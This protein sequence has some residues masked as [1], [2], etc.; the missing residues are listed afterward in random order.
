M[1]M[2]CPLLVEERNRAEEMR[3]LFVHHGRTYAGRCR[4]GVTD[5]CRTG[6][7]TVSTGGL[8]AAMASAGHARLAACRC[9]LA[10]AV[11]FTVRW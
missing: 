2:D 11:G 7:L 9:T 6:E 10:R 4:H 5:R 1:Q 3:E 8:C